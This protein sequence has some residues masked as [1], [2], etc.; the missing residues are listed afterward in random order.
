MMRPRIMAARRY[1]MGGKLRTLPV[2]VGA[3]IE[4]GV[5]EIVSAMATLR[6]K[7]ICLQFNA[8]K[9]CLKKWISQDSRDKN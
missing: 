7:N 3:E 6:I 1:T 5:D 2:D 9:L 4:D 8:S